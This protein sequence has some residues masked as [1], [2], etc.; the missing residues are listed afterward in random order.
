[1]LA[2]SDPV[3]GSVIAMLAQTPGEP[4]LLLVVGHRGDGGVAEALARHREQQADVAPAHLGDRHHRGEVGAVPDPRRPPL[5]VVAPDARGAR[6][7]RSPRTPRSRRSSRR[8]CRAPWGTRAR[9]GRTCG[10]SAAACSSRPG[11]PGRRSGRSFFGSS[12]LIIRPSTPPSITP[13]ALRSRYHRSTGCSLTK[14]W[15]PSSCTPSRPICMPLSAHSLRAS[16]TSRAK[17]LPG[18]GAGR[19][20]VGQQPH[21]LQLDR[22]VGDHE[23]HRLTVGD[24]LAERLALLDVRRHVV[25]HRLA[26]ADRQGAP[27][28][29]REPHALGVR[30]AVGRSRARR[31]S[32][33][34]DVR[35]RE[36]GQRRRL[37]RPSRG[38]PRPRG[39]RLPDSTRNSTGWPRR[40]RAPTT[41]SSASAPRGT[42]DFT[43]LR[44]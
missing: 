29:A 17:S 1:M 10:R 21:R 8:A 20:L 24:R 42:S 23:R 5:L 7:A 27:G 32:G 44:T 9:R 4:L 15:P 6:A 16:A 31:R 19:G 39:R 12:R 30:R 36:P 26:G 14:P 37:A 38:R 28:E 13:I 3:P 18:G 2:E 22:D 35:Q 43:P 11:A 33:D 40:A 41:N 25:E 34:R